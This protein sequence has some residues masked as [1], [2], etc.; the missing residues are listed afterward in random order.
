MTNLF[1]KS[2]DKKVKS[3]FFSN[4][5]PE[6]N[7][8]KSKTETKIL[9]EST[10]K[11]MSSTFDSFQVCTEDYDFED[12]E[13]NPPNYIAGVQC[14]ENSFCSSIKNRFNPFLN[15]NDYPAQLTKYLKKKFNFKP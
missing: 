15:D 12:Y 9:I 13:I 10:L 14:S 2:Q 4:N 1:H 7:I 3:K 8:W 6:E 5:L 11:S